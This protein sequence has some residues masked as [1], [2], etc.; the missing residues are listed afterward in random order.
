MIIGYYSNIIHLYSEFKAFTNKYGYSKTYFI[1]TGNIEDF[2]HYWGLLT[3]TKSLATLVVVDNYK[4]LV[5]VFVRTHAQR[6]KLYGH[7]E[8]Y[9]CTDETKIGLT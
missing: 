9:K 1:S 2:G 4:P 7:F 6:Y 5:Y 3:F 8:T